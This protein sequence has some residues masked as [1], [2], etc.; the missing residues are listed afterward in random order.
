MTTKREPFQPSPRREPPMANR[1]DHTIRNLQRLERMFRRQ[2]ACPRLVTRCPR[3][4]WRWASE[5]REVF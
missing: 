5:M 4:T 2:A 1:M 3:A